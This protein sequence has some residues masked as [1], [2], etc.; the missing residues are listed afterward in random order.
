[1]E[2]DTPTFKLM[3]E[4]IG[5]YC[6]SDTFLWSIIGDNPSIVYRADIGYIEFA[7]ESLSKLERLHATCQLVVQNKAVTIPLPAFLQ[8]QILAYDTSGG[9]EYLRAGDFVASGLLSP[10]DAS[11]IASDSNLQDILDSKDLLPEESSFWKPGK[12]QPFL[13]AIKK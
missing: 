8:E 4:L 5:T 3:N 7:G 12:Y 1:M 6:L 9:T 2:Y 13:R 10:E 11:Q